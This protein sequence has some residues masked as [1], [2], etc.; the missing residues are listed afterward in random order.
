M[1]PAGFETLSSEPAFRGKL[2]RVDRLEVRA[3]DGSTVVRELVTHPGSVAVLPRDG[4]DV[5]LLRQMRV[6]AGR[7]LLEIPAGLL[8]E[9]GESPEVAAARECEEEVGLR[10]GRLTLLASFFN[11][12]GYSDE[13]TRL[14]LAEDLTEVAARPGNA[15]ERAATVVR[16]HLDAALAMVETGDI[17][18]AKTALALT[19]A[20]LGHG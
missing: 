18:D 7:E 3:P 11:S 2:L 14:Y 5:V 12:P 15:E 9:P 17:V 13:F 10:P 1:S 16:L 19:L 6:P 8:D 20:A 4:D